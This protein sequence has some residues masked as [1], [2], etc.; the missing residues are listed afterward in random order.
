MRVEDLIQNYVNE[1]QQAKMKMQAKLFALFTETTGHRPED[2]CLVEQQ[3]KK[4]TEFTTIYYFD[5]KHRHTTA[6][7]SVGPHER[8]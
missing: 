5:W 8:R 2:L 1:G 4:G 3:I 7:T 6:T